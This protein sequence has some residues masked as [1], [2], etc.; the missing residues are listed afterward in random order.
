MRRIT[1]SALVVVGLLAVPAVALGDDLG[2]ALI[3]PAADAVVGGLVA[4]AAET[5]GPALTVTFEVSADEV[6]WTAVAGDTEPGDGWTGSW[7]TTG[8]DGEV[9]VRA[10]ASDG[11]ATASAVV[12]VTVDNTAPTVAVRLT[13]EAFSPNDDGRADRTGIEIVLSEPTTLT[14]RIEDA[15]GVVRP[16]RDGEPMSTGPTKVRWRGRG[17]SVRAVPDGRY[18]VHVEAVDAAGNV[19][20]ADVP[21]TV[22]TRAPTL[23]WRAVAPDPFRGTGNVRFSFRIHDRAP[24]LLVRG[25]VTDSMGR[26]I[27]SLPARRIASGLRRAVWDGRRRDGGVAEPGLQLVTL[28]VA[29]DAGNVLTTEP[30]PFRNHR[31]AVAGVLRRVEGAGERVALTFDDCYDASSWA[32]I[33]DVLEARHAGGS[34]FCLG[35]YVRANPAIARRT[36]IQGH[37]VGSHG[38]DHHDVR[39]LNDDQIRTRLRLEADVWWDVARVT[40]VPY[41]RPPG[42]GLDA[43]ASRV[44]GQEGFATIV[45]WDVDPWDWTRPGAAAVTGRVLAHIRAGS[46]VVLHAIPDTATAL[47]GLIDALRARGL[48][49]VTLEELLAAGG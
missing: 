49:P 18:L 30:E 38:W 44:I 6:I 12:H 16:L 21:V 39:T 20:A 43:D 13:N 5:T 2:V 23:G 24:T 31:P 10:T 40:P 46:I 27:A 1:L 34:F 29:D 42:G 36:V 8:W 19:G 48:E 3:S 15:D 9:S 28:T 47:P 25:L 4:L 35:P 33:L 7:D 14:V 17:D 37:T 41:F 26:P 45:L 32:R 22:D 11:Q